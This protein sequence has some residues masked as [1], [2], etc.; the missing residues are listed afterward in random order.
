MTL[1]LIAPPS[2]KLPSVRSIHER[3]LEV[4][5]SLVE[6]LRTIYNPPVRGT[7]RIDRKAL[8]RSST[9]CTG[10]DGKAA[11]EALRADEF[12]R[13]YAVRWLNGLVCQASL[14]SDPLEDSAVSGDSYNV[15]D[16]VDTLIHSATALIAVCAGSAALRTL[17]RQYAFYAPSLEADVDISLTD[18]SIS[19]DA[20]SATVGT[21]TWGSACLMAEML[22]EEPGKFGLTDEVLSRAE[23]VRVL[24][25]GAGTGLV[26][27][28]A[29]K[30]L[31][32]R[33]VKA[34]VVA[35]D[36]HPAVLSNL[37]H[38]IAANFPPPSPA[39]AD[40]SLCAHALDWS[41]FS[42]P[43]TA[44]HHT[45]EPPF[46][47]PFDVILGADIIY[48]LTHALWIR[49][50]VAALLPPSR[51]APAH[52]PA[53]RFHLIIPLRP[54]HTS[55]SHMV[56]EVFLPASIGSA[57]PSSELALCVLEKETILCEVED[58]RRSEVEYLSSVLSVML[59]C[60]AVYLQLTSI[61][62]R[63]GEIA[64]MG[65]KL[66]SFHEDMV[67]ALTV[68]EVASASSR[69]SLSPHDQCEALAGV[70]PDSTITNS[71][72]LLMRCIQRSATH[73]RKIKSL[74][75]GLRE[76]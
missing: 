17:T 24:E 64:H 52:A 76:E 61:I 57:R 22:V 40:V 49:D 1:S 44:H 38:N 25:L 50:T 13:A 27:L 45:A 12:E 33:G 29:A 15:E 32:M 19:V 43:G 14:L 53:P 51:S 26:S 7:R 48:E 65:D 47:T 34:T 2:S 28:A 59:F 37:A 58:A 42:L 55:E 60:V 6:Y 41:K 63:S 62:L 56:E 11:L 16:K 18:L 70:G 5:A 20:D 31:S 35:S 30:Y 66:G 8:K 74:E 54:T 67:T 46:D 71:N 21:Q 75:L 4:L 73:R 36:Y 72:V 23:G 10:D 9:L 69:V 3:P 39:S 68:S